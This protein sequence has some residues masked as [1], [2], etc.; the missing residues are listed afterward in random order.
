MKKLAYEEGHFG[1]GSGEAPDFSRIYF[2][3]KLPLFDIEEDS[4][5]L[6]EKSLY[7]PEPGPAEVKIYKSITLSGRVDA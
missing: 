7:Q 6:V 4:Y 1:I 5:W 2:Q 3:E